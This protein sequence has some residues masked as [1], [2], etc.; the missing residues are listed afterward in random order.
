METAASIEDDERDVLSMLR[1]EALTKNIAQHEHKA[2]ANTNEIENLE[3]VKE[4]A[5]GRFKTSLM[6]GSQPHTL[7]FP[8]PERSFG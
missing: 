7:H 8:A 5:W 4:P 1:R 2:G 3:K 6:F